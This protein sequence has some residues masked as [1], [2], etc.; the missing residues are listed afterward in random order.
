MRVSEV[1]SGSVEAFLSLSP[2][3]R[4]HLDD[5]NNPHKIT[6]EQVGLGS[7]TD[8]KQ[9]TEN[10]FKAHKSAPVLEH[11][12][13]SVTAEKL[14]NGAVTAEKIA[15]EAVAAPSIQNGSIGEEKL[16][17]ALRKKL[18]AKVDKAEGMGLS[19]ENFTKGEKAKLGAIRVTDGEIA[20]QT[21]NLVLKSMPLSL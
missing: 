15:M 8:D 18:A 21:E 14:A 17:D 13:G 5:R 20:L 9:A 7:V 11:A 4:A 19:E 2:E 12:D 1:L 16:E 10:D 6:K 3:T